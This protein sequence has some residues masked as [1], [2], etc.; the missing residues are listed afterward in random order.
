MSERPW[1]LV[2]GAGRG[3]GRA[4]AHRFAASG[5]AVVV[6]DVDEAAALSTV[7]ELGD[8][9]AVPVDVG[10]PASV[11]ALAARIGPEVGG[12][13]R[14]VVNNA[15]VAVERPFFEL[16]DGEWRRVLD[17]GLTGAF[18]VTRACWPLLAKPGAAVVNVSSVHGGRPLPGQA[19][20]AAAKGGLENLTHALALDAGPYGVR[21]NAV[22]PGFVVTA[23]W[24]RWLGP[25]GAERRR[26][27]GAEI[28][29]AVPLGRPATPQ[30][31][32]EVV[33]W[34][35]SPAAAYVTGAVVPVDGGLAAQAFRP[36]GTVAERDAERGSG[37]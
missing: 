13:L 8:A 4:I 27:V 17:A 35:A 10:E 12:G 29:A 6:A 19:A 15:A 30:D 20:Y 34:L 28:D 31:V 16:S 21:V 37:A 36:L 23:A 3:I 9:I 32:A 5:H 25:Q 24:D 18:L 33:H 26:R 22:A 14:V 7:D 2:T 11:A 1:A